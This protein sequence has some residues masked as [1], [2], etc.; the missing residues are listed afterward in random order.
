MTSR[1]RPTLAEE[2]EGGR[3]AARR[4][5]KLSLLVALIVAL[6][7]CF[8][9]VANPPGV[10]AGSGGAMVTVTHAG[11]GQG[12]ALGGGGAGGGAECVPG[13]TRPCY[14]GPAGTAGV[15]A[16]REGAQVCGAEGTFGDACVGEV[17]PEPETCDTPV[18]DDCNGQ[19]NEGGLHCVCL[20]GSMESCYTGPPGTLDVGV[21]AGGS[22]TCTALGK[23]WGPCEGDVTPEPESCFDLLD[24]DCNGQVNEGGEGCV[25]T[26]GQIVPCYTGSPGTLGVGAC[27]GGMK[28]CNEQGSGFGAC[29]GEVTPLPETCLTPADDDCNG[30]VNE[31]GE[32]CVCVPGSTTACYTGPPGTAGVGACKAGV[33]TCAADGLGYG[34]CVGEALPQPETCLTPIDDDCNGQTNEGGV[35]CVCPPNAIVPCYTGPPGTAGVGVCKYGAATCNAMGTAYGTCTGDVLPQPESCFNGV[36][37][38]CDGQ[39]NESCPCNPGDVV[40]CYTGPAGS[41]GVGICAAGTQSCDPMTHTYGP[42]VG[43]VLPQPETCLTPE[44]DD[45]NGVVNEGGAGCVCVPGSTSACYTGPAGTEGIGAC[46]AGT[47]T[48]DAQGLSYGPCVG[49]VVPQAETCLTPV[50]DDCN[51]MVN[52]G[53]AGCV[54]VPGTTQPCYT[55]PAGTQGVGVCKGG[56]KTCAADGLGYGA[57]VGEVVPQAEKCNTP[58]DDNC[59]GQVNEAGAGCICTPGA[60]QP[61]YSGPPGTQGVGACV[62]G[63]QVCNGLGTAWGACAGEVVPQPENCNTTADEDCDGTTPPC[64]GGVAWAK[65]FG[66]I[67]DEEGIAVAVDGSNNVLLAGYTNGTVDYGCGPLSAAG[68]GDGALVVK[69]SP[70][71]SC[72]WSRSLGVGADAMSV[73]VDAAGNVYLHGISTEATDFGGGVIPWAGGNDVFVVKLD[74]NGNFLWAKGYG[75]AFNQNAVSIVVDGPGDV[76]LYGYFQG[77]VSFGGPTLTSA[78]GND[79]YVAKLT[80]NGAH[81][82]SKRFGELSNQNAKAATL[83]PSGNLIIVGNLNGSIDFGGGMLTSAGFADVFVAKLTSAGAHVWSKRFG[84]SSDQNGA[85]VATD[86]QGNVILAGYYSGSIDFGGGTLTSASGSDV[87]L[88]KLSPAGAHVWS[89]TFPGTSNQS[90][91]AVAVDPSGACAITGITTGS[92]DFGGGSGL[93]HAGGGDVYVA[94]YDAN[95]NH[96]WSRAFGD[97]AAQAGKAIAVDSTGAAIITGIY[98][99]PTDFGAGAIQTFGGEDLF[100]A[101]FEP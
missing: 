101:K 72:L 5:W 93:P 11:G 100:I 60:T 39:T 24:N 33:A 54:C 9:G 43:D 26:P 14:S 52:E 96:L 35:G 69:Y 47:H 64:A 7:G 18:D 20:P 67:V 13:Q 48:C 17:T 92:T 90:A 62:G 29:E 25:C 85:G 49:D 76:Y 42:C 51:G 31:G 19:V 73:A 23:G 37:D 3:V 38:N 1:M 88:T 65:G 86:P 12:G 41:V 16:C 59:N 57:C 66:T 30:Q 79:L 53:G 46:K 55:G 50:D 63:M 6:V 75:D 82:W 15:G 61:C 95:G 45:C 28:T 81:V 56:V 78:G 68:S 10:D 4:A 89:K 97:G 21:C 44:D 58:E 83:D 32:G 98:L 99:G 77:T 40:S 36:D 22:R 34:P 74:P 80:T 70:S 87:Y 2:R 84:D 27:K 71:G 94:K 8:D 91:N